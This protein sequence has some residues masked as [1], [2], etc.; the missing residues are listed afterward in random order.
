M[1]GSRHRARTRHRLL[2]DLTIGPLPSPGSE[3]RRA[4]VLIRTAL[5]SGEFPAGTHLPSQHTLCEHFGLAKPT[6]Q[7]ALAGLEE[8]GFVASDGSPDTFVVSRLPP[9]YVL[10][11]EGPALR[12]SHLHAQFLDAV[13]Q[14][15]VVTSPD[16]VITYWN[17]AAE[18]LFGYAAEEAIGRDV[19]EVLPT[20]QPAQASRRVLG[21][22]ASGDEVVGEIL[23]RR[24]DGS[25][26]PVLSHRTPIR[27]DAGTVTGIIGVSSDISELKKIET[28]LYRSELRFRAIFDQATVGVAQSGLDGKLVLINSYFLALLGYARSDLMQKNFMEIIHPDD[29]EQNVA[30]HRRLI[31]RSITSYRRENRY[32]RRDGISVWTEST[33]S[34]MLDRHGEPQHVLTVVSDIDARKRAERAL[35]ESEQRYR[36]LVETSPDGIL[37]ND[38]EGVILMANGKL[39]TMLGYEAAEQL[40]GVNVTAHL[41]E[42]DRARARGILEQRASGVLPSSVHTR[43]LAQ[44]RDGSTF[45]AEVSS[46]VEAGAPESGR[47]ITSTVRDVTNRVAYEDQLRHLALHDPLTG[48]ANRTLLYDRLQQSLAGARRTGDG[49]SVLLL[50]LDHFKEINDTFG[51]QVGDEVIREA[52]GRL[53]TILRAADTLARMGGD[54]F[55]V[56]LPSTDLLGAMHIASRIS[57]E[58]EKPFE[59]QQQR[60]HVGTSI[61][62]ALNPDHGDD[63]DTLLRHADVAMYSAKQANTGYSIY[64]VEKDTHSP[65]SLALSGE[66]RDAIQNDQLVLYFQPKMRLATGEVDGMEALVR[67]NHPEHGLIPPDQFIPLAE[68]SGLIRPLT[69]WVLHTAMSQCRAWN[70]L[71]LTVQIEVNISARSLHDPDLVE[72]IQHVLSI[73][74]VEP[75]QLTVEITE[76]V[77][78]ADPDHAMDLLEQLTSAGVKIAIDDFGTGYSSLAYLRHLRAHELKIDKSFVM[79]LDTN[80]DNQVIVH[81]VI[82]LGHS[83]GLEVVAEGVENQ[84]TLDLL[85]ILKCDRVQGFKLSRPQSGTDITDWLQRRIACGSA[86]AQARTGVITLLDE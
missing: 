68:H 41:L 40:K 84:P 76:S 24:R 44:R 62:I 15:V 27:D 59:V 31:T 70:D 26:V 65:V 21:T 10:E 67:W 54:E 57:S 78:M 3:I 81:S 73:N 51:H 58:L 16:G 75:S 12:D 74:D 86:G 11:H 22:V 52:S 32:I 79:D 66:L 45:P 23:V 36:E 83:L 69:T 29:L 42:Q 17:R 20:A 5:L 33:A 4:Y 77:L 18:N 13:G 19:V 61:G 46:Y 47:L 80:D 9:D 6:L 25:F 7:Q 55:V 34:L 72:A 85:A 71:H 39:A 43:Y 63:P 8:D 37:L 60:L 50:D 53:T 28:E 56:V 38:L 1:G 48:L 2:K 14:A 35:Q 49:L 82:E 30:Q 64:A